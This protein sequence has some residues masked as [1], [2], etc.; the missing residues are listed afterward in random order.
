MGSAADQLGGSERE[1]GAIFDMQLVEDRV[2]IDFDRALG[3]A[4]LGGDVAVAQALA[5][6]LN[7]LALTARQR[8]RRIGALLRSPRALDYFRIDPSI[9]SDD[10]IHALSE[11]P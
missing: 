4:E 7:Q 11:Q 6:K 5:D 8:R 2:E 1:L 3:D 10:S 9:A